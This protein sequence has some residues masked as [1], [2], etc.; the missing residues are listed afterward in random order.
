MHIE[1]II[2]HDGSF[3][4]DEVMAIALIFEHLGARPVSRTRQISE[5]EFEDP[6]VWVI[7][8]GR[9]FD[10]S[11]ACFDHHQD[12]SLAAS[13]CLLADHLRQV[14]L[15]PPALH[16]EMGSILHVV[17]DMDRHGNGDYN[18]IQFSWVIRMLGNL[19]DGFDK[20]IDLCRCVIQAARQTVA[21]QAASK[22]IWDAGVDIA[23]RARCCSDY[24]VLWK[25]YATHNLLIYPDKDMW[26]VVTYDSR[27]L[28]LESTGRERFMHNS[29]FTAGFETREAA[30]DCARA[31]LAAAEKQLPRTS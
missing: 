30:E 20:A 29:R 4:A 13:C 1:R 7:D 14:G 25:R 3:H 9:R 17:S 15:M 22:S 26:Y 5:A 19:E 6:A 10:P 31:T 16:E 18:G 27:V 11:R 23:P 28:P 12:A 2:T 24:P 21:D 8:V